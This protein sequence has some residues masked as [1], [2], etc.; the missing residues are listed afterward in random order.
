MLPAA[1]TSAAAATA[2]AAVLPASPGSIVDS[3][4]VVVP[5][6]VHPGDTQLHGG[7]SIAVVVARGSRAARLVGWVVRPHFMHVE[8]VVL[9][10]ALQVSERATFIQVAPPDGPLGCLW[11]QVFHEIVL[12]ER[13]VLPSLNSLI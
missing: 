13:V 8:F 10:H 11:Q 5:F 9:Q 7:G 4:G 1:A 2:A 12:V 6:R 3:A